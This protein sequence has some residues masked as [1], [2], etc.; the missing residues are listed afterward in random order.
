MAR[1]LGAI[2]FAGDA[3]MPWQNSGGRDDHVLFLDGIPERHCGPAGLS[4]FSWQ[5]G[6]AGQKFSPTIT[7]A[8]GTITTCMEVVVRII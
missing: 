2:T 4:P 1:V 7:N 3:V 8:T 5:R 6:F